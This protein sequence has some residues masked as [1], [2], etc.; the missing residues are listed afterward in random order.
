MSTYG[1]LPK[2]HPL[3]LAWRK[4]EQ[5]EEYRNA[6]EWAAKTT[7][8]NSAALSGS[9][10]S[11]FVEGWR[12]RAGTPRQE[13]ADS[14]A[15]KLRGLENYLLVWADALDSS[16]PHLARRMREEAEDIRELL[17]QC[18]EDGDGRGKD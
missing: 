17:D 6:L 16:E 1:Q 18:E 7:D 11:M 15:R 12:A 3:V 9:L 14:L 8:P 10:W 2:D 4:V 13:A 5:G